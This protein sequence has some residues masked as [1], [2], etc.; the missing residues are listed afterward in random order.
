MVNPIARLFRLQDYKPVEDA[1]QTRVVV[2]TVPIGSS[3]TESYAGYPQEEY[4]DDLNGS[5]KAKI[6]DKMRRSDAQVKALL[7]AVRN[8]ILAAAWDV[9]PAERTPDAEADAKLIKHILFECMEKPFEQ[10][11]SE[12]L[13]IFDFGHSVFEVVDKVV[14]NHPELGSF[15]A[16]KSLG[17]RSPKT[18]ERW[19]LD[20]QT[21][22]LQ[23]IT[24]YSFGDLQKTVD[25]PA[26]FLIVFSLDKEGSLY[27]GVS[28]IRC[29]YGNWFRKNHYQKMNAIGIEKHAIPTPTIEVP[30][31]KEDGEQFDN[32]IAALEA[33][34]AH[35]KNY[36]THPAGW[37]ITLNNN[38]YDPQKVETSIDNED[39]R[40]TKA[41]LAN[42][43]ELGMN[44]F[45]S[46]SLSFDL[47]DFFLKSLDH[48]ASIISGEINRCLIPRLIQL[49][50]G[51]RAK[52]PKLRHSGI[53]DKAGKELADI[54]SMLVEKKVVTADDPLEV[55]L[56]TRFDLPKMDPT[57]KR[58][59]E[60]PKPLFSLVE[61]VRQLQESRRGK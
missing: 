1:S 58:Q 60:A 44:G 26:E 31:G 25:I 24:Q 2:H 3:G 43:L 46:Q 16:I 54:V 57:T 53:S 38:V 39:K 27:E 37:K 11:L 33:Y 47:S 5:E 48:V 20:P 49:N 30:E 40:M 7:K 15:N 59:F 45:G 19:N 51:P 56:R 12:A 8:P 35:E 28:A 4:L 36:L 21:D 13:G 50:R 32:L 9:E 52:Y 42:F 34:M 14:L 41:F 17:W 23:S 18:I 61:R 22:L 29:C 55:H 10:F 6:Y